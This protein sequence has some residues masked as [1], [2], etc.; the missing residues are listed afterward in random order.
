MSNMTFTLA[1]IFFVFGLIIGSFL[2][3]VIFRF[4]TGKSFGGRSICLYCRKRLSTFELVPLFSFLFLKGRCKDCKG[5]I[6]IQY[7][8]VE[9]ITGL[10][11]LG[12]F[13]KLENT[14]YTDI[15]LFSFSFSYY[16]VMFCLLIS[17]SFYDLRH[18]IIPDSMV[19][20]F[21]ILAFA[22]LF[23]FE[24]NLFSLHLPS[25]WEM[26]RGVFFAL[27]FALIWYFSNG[28]WMGFGDA[29]LMLPLAWLLPLP[30]MLSALLIAFWTGA[31]AGMILIL[32]KRL[33]NGMKSEIPLAPFLVLGTLLVFFFA[34]NFYGFIF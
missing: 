24:N 12:L 33:S 28:K 16:A 15:I 26:L 21:G 17:I 9:F 22:S 4:N 20:I 11:F 5:K 6:S 25:I 32:I 8:A 14:F 7:P 31:I 29:K 3:V 2:N 27:P 34:F 1:T 19:F 18:K 30:L 10:I 23:L 13:L